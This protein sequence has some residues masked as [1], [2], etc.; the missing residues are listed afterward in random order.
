MNDE[1]NV[2]QTGIWRSEMDGASKA[3][4]IQ[5]FTVKVEPDLSIDHSSKHLF[6]VENTSP[7]RG[8]EFWEILHSARAGKTVRKTIQL[9]RQPLGIQV[10]RNTLFWTTAGA[11]GI[12]SCEKETGNNLMNH[13]L[14][15]FNAQATGFLIINPVT[16]YEMG[17]NICT[18]GALCSHMCIPT[19]AGYMRCLCPR[20]CRLLQDKR[21]CGKTLYL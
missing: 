4:F 1:N 20:G 5:R 16:Y 2:D 6:W 12:T 17:K 8:E 9:R 21:N 14:A 11:K 13:Q 3:V 19:P 7:F 18:A 15:E 10:S